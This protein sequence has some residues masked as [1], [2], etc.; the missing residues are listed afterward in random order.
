MKASTSKAGLDANVLD[1]AGTVVVL[2]GV[3]L[4]DWWWLMTGGTCMSKPGTRR[5]S[6]NG[7]GAREE[8]AEGTGAVLVEKGGDFE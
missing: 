5:A 3:E 7:G 1:M 8:D 6:L 4:S 2:V